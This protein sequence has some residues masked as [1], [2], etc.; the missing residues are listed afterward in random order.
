MRVADIMQAF[1]TFILALAVAALIGRSPFD[2]I[3]V[4]AVVYAPSLPPGQ[5]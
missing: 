3:C 1:P 4:L 5:G 2:L